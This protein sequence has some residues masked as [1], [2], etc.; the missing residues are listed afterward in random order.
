MERVLNV[1]LSH[2]SPADVDRLAK[3]WESMIGDSA[4]LIAYGGPREAFDKIQFNPKIF[5]D[6]PSLRTL[7]H[8]REGQSYTAVFKEVS[9]WFKA[10]AHPA[11]FVTLFEFDHTP[12]VSDLNRRQIERMRA[13]Q[14]DV[15]AYH[16]T[17]VDG[18]SHAHYLYYAANREFARFLEDLSV[19]SDRQVILSMFG[20]GS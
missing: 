12:L 20:T 16:L 3:Y 11:D 6:D 5:I 17:R 2:Q 4:V 10:S 18:T 9:R 14:A 19:R 13:E 8:Q 1:V 7:D 15:V